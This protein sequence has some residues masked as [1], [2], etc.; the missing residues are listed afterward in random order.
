MKLKVKPRQAEVFVDGYFAGA[1]D[2]YDG[3]FQRLRLDPGPHRI[4]IRMDGYEPLLFE[5]RVQPDKTITYKSAMRKTG[6]GN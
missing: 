2:D 4:E 3:T 5:V 6:G 1:V